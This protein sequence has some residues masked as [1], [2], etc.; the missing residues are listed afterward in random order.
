MTVV[1]VVVVVV[2][3]I[4]VMCLR[5]QNDTNPEYSVARSLGEHP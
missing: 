3:V 4:V 5:L 2:V 1:V